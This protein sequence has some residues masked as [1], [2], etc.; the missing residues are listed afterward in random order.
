MVLGKRSQQEAHGLSNNDTGSEGEP[1][2]ANRHPHTL[3]IEALMAAMITHGAVDEADTSFSHDVVAYIDTAC[4]PAV[5]HHMPKAG[6]TKA[7]MRVPH[8]PKGDSVG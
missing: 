5:G 6:V 4:L 1:L 2:I 8:S 7:T 3:L